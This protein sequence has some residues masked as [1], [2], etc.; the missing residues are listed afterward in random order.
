MQ[1]RFNIGG[2]TYTV[3]NVYYPDGDSQLAWVRWTTPST[4]QTMTIQSVLQAAAGQARQ[5][6]PPRL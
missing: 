1:K 2:K 5:P 6:S 4:P 3:G